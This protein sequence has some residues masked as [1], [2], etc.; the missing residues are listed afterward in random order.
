MQ[1]LFRGFG[2]LA[3]DTTPCGKPLPMAHAH[4][5]MA[6]L[7]NG[8]LSQQELGA[9]LRI[10]KSNVARLC[11]KMVEL[12]HVEQRPSAQDGRSRIVSL[13]APGKRLASEVE[14][15]SHRRF[16]ALLAAVPAGRRAPLIAALEQLVSAIEGL[17]EAP[18]EQ[19]TR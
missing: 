14:V 4:A 3:G 16:E 13:T 19:A 17:P 15:A 9:E 10:D 7:A 6:L 5:L 2:A 1:Q 11:A 12:G 8:E 18:V